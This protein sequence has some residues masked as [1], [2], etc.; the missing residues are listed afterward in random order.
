M[1]SAIMSKILAKRGM[2]P[3]STNGHHS[4]PRGR[5]QSENTRVQKRPRE[6]NSRSPSPHQVK[7]ERR[8]PSSMGESRPYREKERSNSRS[9][10]E[11]QSNGN[12]GHAGYDNRGYSG[13]DNRG[14]SGHDDRGNNGHDDRV[15]YEYSEK[16]ERSRFPGSSSHERDHAGQYGRDNY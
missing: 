7:R 9:H 8:S 12:R 13:Q 15:S 4:P 10:R 14:H 11:S 6:R 5:R 3:A 2:Q 16:K 1:G